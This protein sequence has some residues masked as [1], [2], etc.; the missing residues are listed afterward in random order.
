MGAGLREG[1]GPEIASSLRRKPLRCPAL[2]GVPPGFRRHSSAG[3]RRGSFRGSR[4]CSAAE[5]NVLTWGISI[6][7]IG[8][9]LFSSLEAPRKENG[10]RAAF[11]VADANGARELPSGPVGLQSR[12]GPSSA[13]ACLSAARGVLQMGSNSHS[14]DRKH[15][16]LSIDGHLISRRSRPCLFIFVPPASVLA[17]SS[18]RVDGTAP[19]RHVSKENTLLFSVLENGVLDTI[20]TL[21]KASGTCR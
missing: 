5:S 14:P 1:A 19:A 18:V 6:R 4:C 15:P 10:R 8:K 3:G 13:R 17:R 9:D 2:S 11:Q 20:V 7:A 12:A 21:R 16:S